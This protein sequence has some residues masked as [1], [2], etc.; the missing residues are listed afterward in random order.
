M[1]KCNIFCV[2]DTSKHACIFALYKRVN[3]H[4]NKT[5]EEAAKSHRGRRLRKKSHW[6]RS[7][8]RAVVIL[9]LGAV[10]SAC[11]V[12]IAAGRRFSFACASVKGSR[13]GMVG[14]CASTCGMSA[15]ATSTDSLLVGTL[16][17]LGDAAN[18][19][20]FL[21]K[22][23][24]A[25]AEEFITNY[26]ALEKSASSLTFDAV[27]NLAA[28][29]QSRAGSLPPEIQEML[30]VLADHSAAHDGR[31][32]GFFQDGILQNENKI[33][34]QRFNLLT[35]A[36]SPLDDMPL[37]TLCAAPHKQQWHLASEEAVIA[38]FSALVPAYLRDARL[39]VW[40][41]ACCAAVLAC[42]EPYLAICTQS[43]FNPANMP[44]IAER[45]F[46][47]FSDEAGGRRAIVA[48]QVRIRKSQITAKS[49]VEI[50]QLS[51]KKLPLCIYK[52]LNIYM[53]MYVYTIYIYQ[54]IYIHIYMYVCMCE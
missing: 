30:G 49:T 48:F 42:R 15:H 3:L 12:G 44:A 29:V 33:L 14:P 27:T 5:N 11:R 31:V 53:C 13:L 24:D 8:I 21:P 4:D 16:N 52:Y 9:L 2:A 10:L 54:Y 17:L 25:S 46:R 40:D 34:D 43:V 50:T 28:A 18:P 45:F 7:T 37:H 19:F 23:G 32:W 20:E 35:L 6:E 26:L 36:T 51:V 47:T 38:A 22:G 41:L 39:F 1:R